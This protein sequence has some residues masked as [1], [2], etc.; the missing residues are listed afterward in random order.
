MS[1]MIA[2]KVVSR[3]QAE[4]SEKLADVKLDPV[5]FDLSKVTDDTPPS[6]LKRL[7]DLIARRRAGADPLPKE[8][9][10]NLMLRIG[11]AKGKE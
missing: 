9:I 8:A 7:S 6:E 1:G 11:K 2:R 10:Q 5:E 3:L 4:K